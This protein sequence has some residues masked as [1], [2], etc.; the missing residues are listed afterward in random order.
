MATDSSNPVVLKEKAT[1]A[2]TDL[3]GKVPTLPQAGESRLVSL[4]GF[5][6]FIMFWII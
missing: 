5:R 1:P 4:D 2:S 6:G 3:P